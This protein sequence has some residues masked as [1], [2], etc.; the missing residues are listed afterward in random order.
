MVTQRAPNGTL[1]TI[2]TATSLTGPIAL[3]PLDGNLYEV[4]TNNPGTVPHVVRIDAVGTK[5]DLGAPTGIPTPPANY[6]SVS[7]GFDSTGGL[8]IVGPTNSGVLYRID[9][10]TMTATTLQLTPAIPG[11]GDFAYVDGALYTTTANAFTP[12]SVRRI[13]PA[14]G[15]T[16]VSSPITGFGLAA[17]LWSTGDGH[18]YAS[19]PSGNIVEITGFT[20]Q[21]PAITTVA[22][23]ITAAD[24]ASCPTADNPFLN[25]SD[26]NFTTQLVTAGIGG[27]AG[28][29][30]SNDTLN[31]SPISAAD[32]V[33]TLTS[34]GGLSGATLSPD[35][36]LVVPAG[37]AAGT[38]SLTYRI[39]ESAAPTICDSAQLAVLVSAPAAPAG[40]GSAPVSQAGGGSA[41]AVT[42]AAPS[43]AYTGFDAT[44]PASVAGILLLAGIA[45]ML[46]QR[47][48]AGQQ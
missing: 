24:G 47:R 35:G 11:G 37:A 15:V 31:G 26:D 22:T 43:L 2:T 23:G 10:A 5:T 21:T 1:T 45:L 38:Y 7:G 3:D 32:V 27:T 9:V 33:G 42:V 29:V 44:V 18:L 39:C 28:N 20:G 40:G 19:Q 17:A 8:W 41:P 14:T 36:S 34:D 13:D 48:R 25:A 46:I 6:V 4:T 16:T 30:F 12:N